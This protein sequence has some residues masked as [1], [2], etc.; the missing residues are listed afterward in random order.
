MVFKPDLGVN[1]MS[2]GR[3]R[4]HRGNVIRNVCE[5]QI[6]SA[7]NC[8]LKSAREQAARSGFLLTRQG[9][10]PRVEEGAAAGGWELLPEWLPVGG[11]P[12][13]PLKGRRPGVS[14]APSLSPLTRQPVA[15]GLPR[16][17]GDL[18]A[19]AQGAVDSSASQPAG[20]GPRPIQ[21][22]AGG[23]VGGSPEGPRLVA[24]TPAGPRDPTGR[25]GL[26]GKGVVVCFC[27]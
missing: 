12:A 6:K 27:F 26:G 24:E 8:A 1:G 20:L 17:S 4:A 18:P 15:C 23:G 25:V 22:G 13:A 10:L 2:G 5:E 21:V 9:R 14:L 3:L 11:V 19:G 7:V 16:A